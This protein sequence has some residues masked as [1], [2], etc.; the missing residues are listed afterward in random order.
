MHTRIVRLSL[1]GKVF[2]THPNLITTSRY[3]GEAFF[4]ATRTHTAVA[5]QE[6]C[7]I[8]VEDKML[9]QPAQQKQER[10]SEGFADNHNHLSL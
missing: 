5:L 7:V 4:P 2:I 3:T 10:R 8:K 1:L 9:S 6:Y